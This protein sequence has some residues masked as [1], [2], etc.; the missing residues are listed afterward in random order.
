MLK[1]LSSHLVTLLP[2]LQIYFGSKDVKIFCEKSQAF[3]K[4]L[5]PKGKK[6]ALIFI[7]AVALGSNPTNGIFLAKRVEPNQ[8]S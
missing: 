6:S 7:G 4:M 2:D 1:K 3:A 8:R 5:L